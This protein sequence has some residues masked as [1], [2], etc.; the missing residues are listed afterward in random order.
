MNNERGI[1][2]Y[3]A[4]LQKKKQAKKMKIAAKQATKVD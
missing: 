2:R 3:Q 1:E 4:A